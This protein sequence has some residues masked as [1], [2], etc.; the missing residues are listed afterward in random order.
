MKPFCLS[1]NLHTFESSKSLKDSLKRRYS[2]ETGDDCKIKSFI[3]FHLMIS[4]T[5]ITDNQWKV[6]G[7]TGMGRREQDRRSRRGEVRRGGGLPCE[8]TQLHGWIS[9][10]TEICGLFYWRASFLFLNFDDVIWSRRESLVW[11][12]TLL[13]S[14]WPKST[15]LRVA[16]VVKVMAVV[17][18]VI[19]PIKSTLKIEN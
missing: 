17:D 11:L 4:A 9:I 18:G 16:F 10:I 3:D 7:R 6:P 13:Q 15:C 8:I 5:T 19:S 2:I 12:D 1:G 14:M